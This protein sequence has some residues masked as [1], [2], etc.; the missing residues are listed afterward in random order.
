M[1]LKTTIDF[2]S[3]RGCVGL[4]GV[5]AKALIRNRIIYCLV[6]IMGEHVATMAQLI[7]A[8][9]VFAILNDQRCICPM[10][11]PA[12]LSISKGGLLQAAA[13][14]L[15]Q[16]SILQTPADFVC[17][18]LSFKVRLTLDEKMFGYS[19][20]TNIVALLGPAKSCGLSLV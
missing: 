12:R 14:S 15:V 19:T 7:M 6:L 4:Q 3:W 5:M 9:H 13:L 20:A 17:L 10:L 16:K 8:E 18:Q 11:F 1:L 2:T